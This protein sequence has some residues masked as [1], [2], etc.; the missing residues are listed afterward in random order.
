MGLRKVSP[1]RW[2]GGWGGGYV[3]PNPQEG[4]LPR[5]LGSP[6]HIYLHTP[7]SLGALTGHAES[8]RTPKS[9]TSGSPSL[10][11]ILGHH[12]SHPILGPTS[13]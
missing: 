5:D 3:A 11:L 2:Q 9:P 12:P 8:P 6:I 10:P 13:P 4:S 1:G 7:L